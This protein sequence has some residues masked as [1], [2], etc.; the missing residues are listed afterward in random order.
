MRRHAPGGRRTILGRLM[1]RPSSAAGVVVLTLLTICALWPT[2]W[3]PHDPFRGDSS[4]RFL[5][6]FFMS[7]G[8]LSYPLGTES[9][10]RD[11]L[12]MLVAGS[13]YTLGIVVSAGLI[14]LVIGVTA[15]LV[16]GYFGGWL[17]SVVMRIADVQ[18]AFPA[19]VLIIA[20]VA[21]FGPSLLNLVLILGVVGWAPYARLVRGSVLSLKEQ[22]FIEAARAT[23]IGTTR[24]L[25]RHLMPNSLTNILVFLT[26]QL[27]E[28][29]VLEASLSFL[30]LG[31]QPPAPSWGGM[32]SDARQ[33][34]TQAWWASAL[35]G[36][37]IVLCVL[38]FNFVGDGLRD[39]MD[40]TM[41]RRSIRT[42]DSTAG[43][44]PPMT[45]QH[46][47]MGGAADV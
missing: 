13:R 9:L 24:I 41:R 16:A 2:S 35:P 43:P 37:V 3:L 46:D 32:I 26:L 47:T 7:G 40:P 39:A 42:A 38:A 14:G 1:R 5:P 25:L 33:Y 23:G 30:G 45:L 12:S 28:L 10:G 34:L 27:A 29:V 36:V 22:G 6:P 44:T 4:K 20:I 19:L 21:A 8:S 18:L 17:D 15:G 31:V 11:V